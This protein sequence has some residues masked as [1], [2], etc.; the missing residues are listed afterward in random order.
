LTRAWA[1]VKHEA[2]HYWSGTKLLGKEIKISA[3]LQWRL[4]NGKAL[5][6]R[7]KRQVCPPSYTSYR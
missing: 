5:T 6:R 7:E 1:T 3:R 2:S 4:L